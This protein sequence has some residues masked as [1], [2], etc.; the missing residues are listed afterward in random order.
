LYVIKHTLGENTVATPSKTQI[1]EY[2]KNSQDLFEKTGFL[3]DWGEPTCWACDI[4]WD[5]KYDVINPK[6]TWDECCKAW[7][8]APLQRCHIVPR[9][10]GGSDEPSNFLLMCAECHDLAP[11]TIYPEMLFK[12]ARSQCHA[13]RLMKKLQQALEDLGVDMNDQR[14]LDNVYLALSSKEF[15]E[16]TNDK[17][18]L[19]GNQRP[20]FGIGFSRSSVAAAALVYCQQMKD[21]CHTSLVI[22]SAAKNSHTIV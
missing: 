5:T 7:E 3:I 22:S 6:A 8:K 12:W 9:S 17:V 19:H 4:W 15:W 20:P 2:S 1:L 10:L 14:Q 16:W 11:D 13:T 21:Q 18:G